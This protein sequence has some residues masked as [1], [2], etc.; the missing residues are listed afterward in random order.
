[1]TANR[2]AWTTIVCCGALAGSTPAFAQ[3]GEE[4]K[5]PDENAARQP[6]VEPPAPPAARWPRPVIARPLTL[7][8]GLAQAGADLTA[9]NDFSAVGFGLTTGTGLVGGYGVTD[10]LEVT[11]FYAFGKLGEDA[12]F[13]VKG[14]LDVDLGYK[15]LR[16]AAGGK[17]EAIARA[18]VGYNV[19]AEDLNPLRLGV[20]AQYNVTDQLAVLTPGPHISIALAETGGGMG[21]DGT[22]EVFFQLPVAVGYQATPELYVQ[23]DTIL[24]KLKIADSNNAF[25]F[26]DST[27]LAVTATYNAIPALDAIASIGINLTPPEAMGVDVALGDTLTFLVGARYYI[28]QL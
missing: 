18:R 13:E 12:D 9:N 11:A 24:A 25:I 27:P 3:E 19:L 16:G 4:E 14:S 5:A 8:K 10:D 2:I 23:L 1:M 15:L 17:L 6:E 7:P 28:G 21:V 22:R 20:Q 26:A